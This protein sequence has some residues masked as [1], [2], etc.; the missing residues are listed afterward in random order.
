M[1]LPNGTAGVG[2]R[3]GKPWPAARVAGV[4]GRHLR[5]GL[6]SRIAEHPALY[7]P[8]ARVKYGQA[9]VSADAK[10]LIDGFTRSGVTFAVIAFQ[11]CQREPV[12]VAH[13][14]HAPAHVAAAVRRGIPTLV[15]I[16]DPEAAV[17]ST[18]IREPYVTAEQGL[19][20]WMRFYARIL[21]HRHGFVLGFFDDIVGDYGRVIRAIN[22]RFGTTFKEFEH[23]PENV[24]TCFSVIEDRARR[25]PWSEALGQFESGLIGLSEY[26]AAVA[27]YGP[28]GRLAPIPES[29]V[30]RPSSER[31]VIKEA[32]V[33]QIWGP[34]LRELRLDARRLF[35]QYGGQV[36]TPI[37]PG[38][39][40]DAGD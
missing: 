13:T 4:R 29:R 7:L 16:R 11:A 8:I 14:L 23:T 35:A 28:P 17:L 34:A 33:A 5:W 21:P 31:E 19:R 9:V 2:Q 10:L 6:R 1:R 3:T 25:P 27:R 38:G 12:R 18:I 30:P 37:D 40:A 39:G 36:T 24:E 20:A 22:D 26:R 15:T 32:L